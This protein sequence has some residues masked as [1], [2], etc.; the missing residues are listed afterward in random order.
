MPRDQRVEGCRLHGWLRSSSFAEHA[1]G[2]SSLAA[3][4]VCE[5]ETTFFVMIHLGATDEWALAT[6]EG[7]VIAGRS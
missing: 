3:A 1:P 2:G 5:L 6:C 4:F 7:E